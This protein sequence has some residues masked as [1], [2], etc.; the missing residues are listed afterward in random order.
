MWWSRKRVFSLGLTK[1]C[2]WYWHWYCL[3]Q[4]KSPDDDTDGLSLSPAVSTSSGESCKRTYQDSP[5][6]FPA[7]S[8][9]PSPPPMMGHTGKS[10]VNHG[11]ALI[12][13]CLRA[14]VDQT[15]CDVVSFLFFFEKKKKNKT[16]TNKKMSGQFLYPTLFVLPA[17]LWTEEKWF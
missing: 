11:P 9:N 7:D 10:A 14:R 13:V 12:S 2:S 5:P 15:S 6:K 17:R 8:N 1:F 3:F 4:S 16:K